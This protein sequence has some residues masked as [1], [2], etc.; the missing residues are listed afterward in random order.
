MLCLV[1]S[2]LKTSHLISG[3]QYLLWCVIEIPLD[4]PGH[5]G[6]Q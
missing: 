4:R 6:R 1:I 3:D 2:A 5:I